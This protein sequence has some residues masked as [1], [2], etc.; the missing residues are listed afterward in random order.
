[1]I[2]F[3]IG[4]FKPFGADQGNSGEKPKTVIPSK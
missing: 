4:E 1:M 2:D 3:G